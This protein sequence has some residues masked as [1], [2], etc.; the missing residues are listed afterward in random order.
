M[1]VCT[2]MQIWQESSK[3]LT[4]W[5]V[6]NGLRLS[7]LFNPEEAEI[8]ILRFGLSQFFDIQETDKWLHHLKTKRYER[9][10]KE[11]NHGL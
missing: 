9:Y 10:R 11:L 2:A 6:R 4:R 7:L 8:F 1:Q 5:I 3:T